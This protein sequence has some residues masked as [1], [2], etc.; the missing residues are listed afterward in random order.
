LVM[1]LDAGTDFGPPAVMPGVIAMD[2]S[3]YIF[4]CF[5]TPHRMQ[6]TGSVDR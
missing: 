6:L 5:R 4:E 1:F 3:V 2:V